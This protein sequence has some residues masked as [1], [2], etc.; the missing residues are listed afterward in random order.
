[1]PVS[2][3]AKCVGGYKLGN[4]GFLEKNEAWSRKM[5]RRKS[6]KKGRNKVPDKLRLQLSKGKITLCIKGKEV[7]WV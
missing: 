5:N 3:R 6:G 4:K 7:I 1:M 2:K